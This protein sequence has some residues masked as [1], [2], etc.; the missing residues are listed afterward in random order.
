[1]TDTNHLISIPLVDKTVKNEKNIPAM[2]FIEE[3]KEMCDRYG[4]EQLTEELNVY[5]NKYKYMEAQT[6]KHSEGIKMKIPDIEKAIESVLFL[7]NKYKE[8]TETKSEEPIKLD[9]MAAQSLWAKA[10]V[11]VVD[12]VALWLGANVLCEYT[13]DD[14]VVLLRKNLKNAQDTLRT[15]EGHIDYLR[16]QI[17][18]SETNISRA[19]NEYVERKKELE[20]KKK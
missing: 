16:D 6:L 5:L 3:V 13:H 12:K 14:A 10:E 9:F 2:M 15:N 7:Q 19:Y 4:A 8:N 1:M 11:P 20:G 18:I 17:T